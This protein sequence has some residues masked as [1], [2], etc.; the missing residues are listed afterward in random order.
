VGWPRP[1]PGARARLGGSAVAPLGHDA[2]GEGTDS[3][4][5]AA[6]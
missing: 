6:A 3:P 5:A 1:A 2:A 4:G